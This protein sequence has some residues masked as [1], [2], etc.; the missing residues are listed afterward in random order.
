MM[1]AVMLSCDD[2]TFLISKAQYNSLNFRERIQLKLHLMGCKFC[3]L[4]EDQS[5]VLTDKINDINLHNVEFKLSD[6]AKEDISKSIDR[7]LDRK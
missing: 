6:K 4:F 3:S 2:A 7:Q 5:Q 1:H